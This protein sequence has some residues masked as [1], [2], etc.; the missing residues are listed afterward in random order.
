[1]ISRQRPVLFPCIVSL[2]Y[3]GLSIWLFHGQ[4]FASRTLRLGDWSAS[5]IILPWLFVA[6]PLVGAAGSYH[7]RRAGGTRAQ[8]ILAA[9]FPAFVPLGIFSVTAVADLVSGT[10]GPAGERMLF[11]AAPFLCW[12]LFPAVALLVGSL[13]F[14]L[15]DRQ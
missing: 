12:V 5:G 13:P 1:M 3:F 9:V 7:S 2:V 15:R 11:L 8:R 4:V 10:H 6:L 14:V